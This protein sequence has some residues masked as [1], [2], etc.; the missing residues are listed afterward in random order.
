MNAQVRSARRIAA[1]RRAASVVAQALETR[2]TATAPQIGERLDVGPTRAL[3]LLRGD[4]ALYLGD[5]LLLHAGDAL[6]VL[7][8][9]RA[10]VMEHATAL[11]VDRRVRRTSIRVGELAARVDDALADGKIEP[12]EAATIRS[13]ALS[14]AAE[15][16]ATVRDVSGVKR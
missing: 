4:A 14:V 12:H 15:A 9:M 7:D 6:A 16:L 5:L 13:A 1:A 11:P 2:P 3:K 10:E 8:A